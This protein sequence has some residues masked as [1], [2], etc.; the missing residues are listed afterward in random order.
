VLAQL[1]DC[2]QP[3][4]DSFNQYVKD[5]IDSLDKELQDGTWASSDEYKDYD[6]CRLNALLDNIKDYKTASIK[7]YCGVALEYCSSTSREETCILQKLYFFACDK[8]FIPFEMKSS[9]CS[10][11]FAL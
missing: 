9:D 11:I 5:R 1:V 8:P 10:T 2:K 3:Q 6:E 7:Y 4:R